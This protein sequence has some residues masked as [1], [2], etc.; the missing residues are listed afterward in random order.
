[1]KSCRGRHFVLSAMTWELV[2]KLFTEVSTGMMLDPGRATNIAH[3]ALQCSELPGDMAE[4][5]CHSGR[6]AALL[7][8]LV[9]KPL[10]LY[11]SF[12]GLPERVA[13][14]ADALPHFKAGQLAV[15]EKEVHAIFEKHKL[16]EPIVHKV[17]FSRVTP[18]QLPSSI[19]FAHLDGDLYTSIRDSLALVYPR[20]V[21]GAACVIDDY[22]WS[23]LTGVKA[24]A[25]EYMA[26]K[27]E[28][29]RSLVTGNP[30]GFQGVIIK[31]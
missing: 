3:Y 17:W 1:M 24:A 18:D 28:K 20:L 9:D 11:D 5:G 10:Y 21:P 4:F 25:D 8:A 30:K 12:E 27:P 26:D 6:T 14:D 22:G 15:D 13:Q 29:V 2:A 7:A 19:C 31:I 23:G 16:R